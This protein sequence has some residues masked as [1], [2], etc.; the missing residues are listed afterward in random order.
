MLP[1][2]L[3]HTFLDD[4]ES[5]AARSTAYDPARPG[6]L[7]ARD[8]CSKI[9]VDINRRG[10]PLARTLEGAERLATGRTK[11]SSKTPVPF[12]GDDTFVISTGQQTGLFTGPLYTIY[13][14]ITAVKLAKA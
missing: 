7:A 9:P 1:D 11:A 5:S 2:H 3:L 4:F 8:R 12:G 14:A 13:K 6:R 10:R